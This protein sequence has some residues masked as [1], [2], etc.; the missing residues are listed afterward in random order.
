MKKIIA[1][2]PARMGSKR[3]IKKNIRL[4]NGKPLI[5]YVI[6]AAK[7]SGCFDE[8]WLN[9]ES[10]ILKEIADESGIKFYKRDPKLSEDNV[11]SDHFVEDFVKNVVC[12]IIVQILPTSPFVTPSQIRG[13]VQKSTEFDTTV[14]TTPIQIECLFKGEAINFDKKLPTPPSQDLEP[15]QS[16][17]CS[18]M[19]WKTK[20]YLSNM[21]KYGSAYHGGDGSVAS[22]EIKG[23]GSIDI[24]NEEDFLLAECVAKSLTSPN[25]DPKYYDDNLVYDA[26]RLRVLLED[27][28]DVNNMKNFN[29]EIAHVPEIIN[30][31]PDD[32][33]WSHTLINSEST[34]VT[35]IAQMPGEGNRLHYHTDW[36]EW[37]YII[38]GTW[39]WYVEGVSMKVTQGDVVFIE[40]N[41]KHK[42]TAVGPGQSIRLAVSREDVDHV[43]TA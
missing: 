27:G 23:Y 13:F 40:R 34:C 31:N 11:G 22:Y 2:I 5:R 10:D 36:D 9:S 15:I 1:M 42:I 43:Y 21:K 24:D 29:K 6:D 3:I 25:Q 41:K 37:W 33:C 7:E 17:A 35:L 14:S 4:L 28:V 26:D 20:S 16:Y 12:D 18:L 32:H 38:K 39:E 19:A 8:I 30:S